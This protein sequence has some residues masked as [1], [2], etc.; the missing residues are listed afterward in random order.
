MSQ[1]NPSQMLDAQRY[2]SNSLRV[3][4]HFTRAFL[5]VHLG[6]GLVIVLLM[7]LHEIFYWAAGVALWYLLSVLAVIGMFS[8]V[9]VCRC[10]LGLIFLFFGISGIFFLSQVL[11][12]MKMEEPALSHELLPFWLGLMNII[13]LSSGIFV[14]CSKHI[15]R[16]TDVGFKL[17]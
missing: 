6:L 1:A 15:R 14:F 9:S 3:E 10:L 11:P 4:V 2:R 16:A 13:Y 7:L 5:W 8:A 12:T 17:W